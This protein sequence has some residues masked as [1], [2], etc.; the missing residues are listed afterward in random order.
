MQNDVLKEKLLD[1]NEEIASFLKL[2]SISKGKPTAMIQC[3]D[4]LHCYIQIG[5]I[6]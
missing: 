2:R 1:I 4:G 6:Q 5:I 3:I